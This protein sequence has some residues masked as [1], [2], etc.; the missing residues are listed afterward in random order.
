MH[1]E[2]GHHAARHEL[3][4]HKIPRQPD[5]LCLA[6]LARQGNL[7]VARELRVAALLPRLHLVPQRAAIPPARRRPVRQ[8]DLPMHHAGLEG[9]V[10]VAVQLVVVQA[11]CRAIRRRRDRAAPRATANHLG[12]EVIDR[13]AYPVAA[14]ETAASGL[15]N[16]LRRNNR[17][18][19]GG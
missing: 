13:H 6:Q 8:H 18:W 1:V 12:G 4:A 17:R 7:D 15:P 10:V 2:V 5:R 14:G 3:L 9:V 16:R 19:P 11:L